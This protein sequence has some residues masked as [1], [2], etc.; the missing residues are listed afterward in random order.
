VRALLEFVVP[1][2]LL[3]SLVG[4]L[5]YA[6]YLAVMTE[7]LMG[8]AS[9]L[10]DTVVFY[11]A[12]STAQSALTTVT[13]FCGLL[14]IPFTVPPTPAW[15]NGEQVRHDWRPTLLAL[16]L[17]VAYL[18]ILAVP[19]L[20]SFFELAPLSLPEYLLLGAIAVGWALLLRLT[21]QARVLDRFLSVE[22][23]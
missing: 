6:A 7:F 3:T 23:S 14:L 13:I 2:A 5:V 22:G 19:P 4:L 11:R 10:S 1:A 12:M 17:L 21:W 20:R 9:R 16:A 8:P 18:V 15:G